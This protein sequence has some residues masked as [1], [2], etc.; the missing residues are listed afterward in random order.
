MDR[1]Y[2]VYFGGDLFNHK[3]LIGNALLSSYIEKCSNGTYKCHLPQSLD[4]SKATALDIRNQDLI[5]IIECDLAL[6]NFD[7]AELDSGTVVEFIFAKL[8]K[9]QN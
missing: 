4:Q 2:Q 1:C 7:G 6:F 8:I 3:D 9:G 5:K